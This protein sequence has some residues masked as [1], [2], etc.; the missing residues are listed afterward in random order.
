MPANKS[1]EFK[2]LLQDPCGQVRWQ[3]G[4]NRALQIAET[5]SALVVY[6]DWDDAECQK[7][8]EDVDP[9]IAAEDISSAGCNGTVLAD[10]NQI[11]EDQQTDKGLTDVGMDID[12][13]LHKVKMGANEANRS[14]VSDSPTLNLFI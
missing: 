2:F 3:H 5:S 4:C 14:E 11:E 1:V 7:V 6:E 13:S 12:S 10:G 8:S 9:L